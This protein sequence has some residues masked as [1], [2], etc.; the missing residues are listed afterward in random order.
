M[1]EHCY[2]VA[3]D[4]C[5]PGRDYSSLIAAI[6]SFSHWGKLTE[7]TWAVVSDKSAIEICDYLLRLIDMNDRLLVVESGKNAA[8]IRMQASDEWIKTNIIK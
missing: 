8:W 7:S 6:K 5:Q 4:L 1:H 3:Y 2:I